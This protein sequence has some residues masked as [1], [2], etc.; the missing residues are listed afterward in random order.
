MGF[1][2]DLKTPVKVDLTEDE[3]NYSL[4]LGQYRYDPFKYAARK[5]IRGNTINS[6]NF[7]EDKKPWYRHFIGA[8][9]EK[10]Y[11][12]FSNWP[13]IETTWNDGRSGEDGTDFPNGANIKA[14]PIYGMPNLLIPVDQWERHEPFSYVLAWVKLR[15][16]ECHLMGLV[17]RQK[18]NR[19][20]YKVKKGDRKMKVDTWW[21]DLKHLSVAD[22]F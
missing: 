7:F 12:K 17:T 21:I 13:I 18:A 6:Q 15:Q 19:V 3:I 16:R 4:W 14:S 11:S 1:D 20:K 2:T 10:A 9:G 22:L 8:I 5:G